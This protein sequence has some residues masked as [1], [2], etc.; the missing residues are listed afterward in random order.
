MGRGSRRNG[1]IMPIPDHNADGLLP[2]YGDDPRK[3]KLRSPF[4]ATTEE[5]VTRF[6]TSEKRIILLQGLFEY[7][8]KLRTLNVEGVQWIGGSF[9]DKNHNRDPGDIDIVTI[10]LREKDK[11]R[12]FEQDDVIKYL[13][14]NSV[15]EYGIDGKFIEIH[16]SD[17]ESVMS[18]I[19][20]SV[21]WS[22]MFSHRKSDDKLKGFVEIEL[23][24]DTDDSLPIFQLKKIADTMGVSL[25]PKKTDSKLRK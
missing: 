2:A 3:R 5:L 15:S 22:G 6:A 17:L 16:I 24:I 13:K 18:L 1:W 11:E 4:K 23:S 8:A 7:R 19:S 12:F 20:M 10:Y 14:R 21:Y 9:I 25:E